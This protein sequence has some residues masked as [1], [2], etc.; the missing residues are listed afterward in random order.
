MFRALD[1]LLVEAARRGL[2]LLL[3][4]T[5]YWSAYGGMR[6]YVAW[7]WERR[8]RPPPTAGGEVVAEAFF[9]DPECQRLFRGAAAALVQRVNTLTGV[10][11]RCGGE[12]AGWGV[13]LWGRPASCSARQPALTS[14]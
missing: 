7:A 4:L 11:Y 13:R 12:E 8:G 2:R 1:W 9:P 10:M 5:N 14:C 6:Q 3:D